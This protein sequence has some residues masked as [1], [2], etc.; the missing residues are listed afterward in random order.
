MGGI[1][2]MTDSV[3]DLMNLESLNEKQQQM[4]KIRDQV[5]DKLGAGAS[6]EDGASNRMNYINKISFYSRLSEY[7]IQEIDYKNK[8]IYFLKKI[9]FIL[10]FTVF[11]FIFKD[12]FGDISQYDN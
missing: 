2:D 1:D 7:Y 9:S 8:W 5:G 3:I 11:I 10:L 12:M 4:Q 6:L